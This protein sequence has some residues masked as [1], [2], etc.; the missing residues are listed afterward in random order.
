MSCDEVQ[1]VEGVTSLHQRLDIVIAVDQAEVE[2]TR[3]IAP[4]DIVRTPN[5]FI[6]VVIE[7]D[8]ES[9]CI[10][11]FANQPGRD[12]EKVAWWQEGELEILGSVIETLVNACAHPFSTNRVQGT[13]LLHF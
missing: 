6:A 8:G 10:A 13:K 12:Y 9:S 11:Y 2:V 1:P 4:W 5:N 7:T 3:K